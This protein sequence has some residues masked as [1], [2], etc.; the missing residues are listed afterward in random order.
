MHHYG[1][2]L[3][4]LTDGQNPGKTRRLSTDP[5]AGIPSGYLRVEVG[6]GRVLVLTTE[7]YTR[8]LKRGKVWRRRQ[9]R[10]QRE[11]RVNQ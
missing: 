1:E 8:G 4:R 11:R 7:E 10:M 5:Y 9:A 3:Y 6:K 2:Y